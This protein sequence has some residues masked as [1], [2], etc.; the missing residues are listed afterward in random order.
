MLWLCDSPCAQAFKGS[1]LFVACNSDV[2]T[3]AL[4]SLQ[5]AIWSVAGSVAMPVDEVA[6]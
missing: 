6:A 2:R 3:E 4:N 1:S 5:C